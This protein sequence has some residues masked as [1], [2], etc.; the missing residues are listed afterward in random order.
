MQTKRTLIG[1]AAFGLAVAA[2][3]PF[4][5]WAA[6]VVPAA[7]AALPEHI[8]KAGVLRLATSTQW[9]PFGYKTDTGEAEGIDI[10][11]VKLLAEKLGLKLEL[12]D[13]K[14]PT[15]IPGV[16]SGRFDIGANQMARTAEREK[17]VRFVVYFRSKMGLLVRRGT[18]GI[19]VNNLCGRTL[20][21]TQGSSQVAIA[22]GLSEKCVKAGQKEISFLY[23]P[24]SADTYLAVA[25]GRGDGFL[26]G[27]ATGLYI[28]KHNDKLEMTESTL[29]ETATIAG[30][31]VAKANTG[32]YDALRLALESAITDGSYRKILDEYGV[33][34]GA[35]TIDE[36]RNPPD[37]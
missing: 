26:T 3:G 7:R 25:N 14:F 6:E 12:E 16:N 29:P 31:V 24:N 32:L 5:A 22:Q 15:I 13:V 8:S 27:K 37:M 10:R 36:V 19:D 1:A 4:G 35:L 11:L 18:T 34:E 9:P 17:V 21:L 20:A 23:Y 30:I 2:F 33:A 28:A